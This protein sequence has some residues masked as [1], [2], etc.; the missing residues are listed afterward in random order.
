MAILTTETVN[1]PEGVKVTINKRVVTVEGPLGNITRDFTHAQLD[2][3]MSGNV[4]TVASWFGNQKA[5]ALVRT[6]AT[7][8]ENMIEGVSKGFRYTIRPVHRHF[9]MEI[10]IADDAKSMKIIK[11]LGGFKQHDVKMSE[12][13]TLR[14]DPTVKEQFFVEGIDLEAVGVSAARIQ[15]VTRFRGKDRRLF[16]DGCYRVSRTN[17][18]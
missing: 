1:V 2:M 9:P 10:V 15:Q 11:F 13:V 18:Q 6:H 16:I 12:G 3:T 17:M 5:R 8:I 14:F 7:H 4:I